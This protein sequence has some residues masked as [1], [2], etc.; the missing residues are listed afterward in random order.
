MAKTT[1]LALMILSMLF[2]CTRSDQKSFPVGL[3]VITVGPDSSRITF[4]RLVDSITFIPLETTPDCLMGSA[5]NKIVCGDSTIFILE[6][7][8]EK[9]LFAFDYNGK[10]KFKIKRVGKGPGEF[11]SMSDFCITPDHQLAITDE[12]GKKII[13]FDHQ[14]VFL[15]EMKTDNAPYKI[16]NYGAGE[17]ITIGNFA[18]GLINIIDKNG[19]RRKVWFEEDGLLRDYENWLIAGSNGP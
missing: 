2:S 9:T 10:F 16:A 3:D 7:L 4:S 11:T 15:R 18:F 13:F 8:S 14:G 1:T 5:I 19:D 6:G 12:V 17:C